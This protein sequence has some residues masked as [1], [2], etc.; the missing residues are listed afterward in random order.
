MLI[1]LEPDA[2]LVYCQLM[3]LESPDNETFLLEAKEC[4]AKCM[5][6]DLG[7]IE[8]LNYDINAIVLELPL[9]NLLAITF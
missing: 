2:A 5:V 3:H 9:L 8:K 4:G 6:L 1:T 7:G